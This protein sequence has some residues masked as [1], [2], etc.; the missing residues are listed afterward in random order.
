MWRCLVFF[1]FASCRHI[2]GRYSSKW[3]CLNNTWANTDCHATG[4]AVGCSPFRTMIYSHLHLTRGYTEARM[5]EC[6]NHG[7]SFLRRRQRPFI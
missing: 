4:L 5:I 1:E 7:S 3:P 6:G 2:V